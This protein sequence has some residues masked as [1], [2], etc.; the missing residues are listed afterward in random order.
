MKV[1]ENTI[2]KNVK[3]G[4][5]SQSINTSKFNPNMVKLIRGEDLIFSDS[6]LTPMKTSPQLDSILSSEEGLMPGVMMMV[7]G[8]PGSGKTTLTLD[9]LARLTEQGLKVLFVSGEMDEVGHYKYCKRMPQFNKV[10]TLF[11]KNHKDTVKETLEYV[12]NLGYDV[13]ALDSIAEVLNM[14]K[15]SNNCTQRT[16]ETFLI[17]LEDAQKKGNNIGKY[18]TTFI[19]IQQMTKAGDASGSNRLKHMVDAFAFIEVDTEQVE[20]TIKFEKN[21]DGGTGEKISFSINTQGVE[22]GYGM[23]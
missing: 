7:A 22:Y 2:K 16:A 8:G 20:R 11:L 19:N 14:Y 23:E 6:L 13:I 15:D 5:P 3:R 9:V 4:R 17:E 10:Q 1:M 21:R 12:F 18:Y